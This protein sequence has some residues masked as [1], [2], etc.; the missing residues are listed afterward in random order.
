MVP[1][2]NEKIGN[3]FSPLIHMSIFCNRIEKGRD[4]IWAIQWK[5]VNQI[6]TASLA[7]FQDEFE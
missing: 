6:E 7:N 3:A 2:V 1:T 5:K 4:R